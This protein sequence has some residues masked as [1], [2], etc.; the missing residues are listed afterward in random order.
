MKKNKVCSVNGCDSTL[1][2]VKGLCSKH[3]QRLRLK[4]D[5]HAVSNHLSRTESERFWEKVM[6]T[7]DCWLWTGA[8]ENGGYGRFWGNGKMHSAHRYSYEQSK[9]DLG[10][11][12]VVDHLCHNRACVNPA[13]LEAA[14]YSQNADNY[15]GVKKNNSSGHRNVSW[16][17]QLDKWI[18]IATQKGKRKHIG[19]FPAYELHC[20]GYYAREYRLTV[21]GLKG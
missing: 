1:K 4:G 8:V 5:V 10:E 14:T 20:A 18:V 2:V 17:K 15:N 3:Y 21:K 11:G 12:L 6:K 13:H 9:G 19:V 16:S 7:S